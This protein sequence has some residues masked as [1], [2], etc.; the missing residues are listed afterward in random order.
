MIPFTVI[1]AA[2][3]AAKACECEGRYVYRTADGP[4]VLA[5]ALQLD[6]TA[7][8]EGERTLVVTFPCAETRRLYEQIVSR[9]KTP[10]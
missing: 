4:G 10:D 5:H 9:A 2:A 7:H 3:A 8:L 1:E 6:L